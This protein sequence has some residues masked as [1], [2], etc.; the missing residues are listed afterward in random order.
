[1]PRDVELVLDRDRDTEQRAVLALRAAPIGLDSRVEGLVREQLDHGVDPSVL[2]LD[3]G[4]GRDGEVTGAQGTGAHR[5]DLLSRS[6]RHQIADIHDGKVRHYAGRV[7]GRAGPD[8]VDD[9]V[10]AWT[11]ERPDVDVTAMQVLSRIARIARVLDQARKQA[12]AAHDLETWEFDVLST[13]R[14]SGPPYDLSPGR[15][16]AETLVTS[17]TMTN[18][19]DRLEARGLV[20]RRPDPG[21][22]RGVLVSLTE[23][24]RAT[25]DAALD[26]LLAQEREILAPLGTA[27]ATRLADGLRSLARNL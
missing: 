9:I 15:L 7:A 21:D 8:E 13:L 16:V 26:E 23:P 3:G 6:C 10:A 27:E 1:M 11:R 25:V 18:R 22:G 24:G 12:F 5:R 14:R 2:A 17:G 20:E 19:I 4:E